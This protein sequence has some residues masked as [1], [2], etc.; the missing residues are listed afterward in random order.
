[1]M[2]DTLPFWSKP[3]ADNRMAS[4]ERVK[5]LKGCLLPVSMIQ[6]FLEVRFEAVITGT[7]KPDI[8]NSL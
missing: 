2:P 6:S 5:S 4:S 3:V 7:K 8:R 1:M